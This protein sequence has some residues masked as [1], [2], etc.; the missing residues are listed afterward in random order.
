MQNMSG[1]DVCLVINV[2]IH[3]SI[4]SFKEMSLEKK[5]ATHVVNNHHSAIN[6]FMFTNRPHHRFKEFLIIPKRMNA[7]DGFDEQY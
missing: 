5:V 4:S 7:R 3:T 6:V 1:I 2:R